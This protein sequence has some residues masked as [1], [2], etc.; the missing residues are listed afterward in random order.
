[1]YSIFVEEDNIPLEKIDLD[2]D[3]WHMHF[4]GSCSSEGNGVG[5]ILVSPTGKIHNLTYRLEF[6]CSNNVTEFE[7]LLLGIE[8]ALNLGCGHLSVFV[9]FELVVNLIRKACS[10]SNRMME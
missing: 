5:V 6:S 8:N 9:N 7:A 10:P 1:V 2:D 4:D 3:I